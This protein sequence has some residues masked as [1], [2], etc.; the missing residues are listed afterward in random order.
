VVGVETTGGAGCG[1]GGG[2]GLE[3]VTSLPIYD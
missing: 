2:W 1:A 3:W